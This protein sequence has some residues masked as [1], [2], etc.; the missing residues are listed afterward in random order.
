MIIDTNNHQYRIWWQHIQGPKGNITICMLSTDG[1][2][3]G[4]NFLS[5]NSDVTYNKK[6]GRKVSF[7]R[8]VSIFNK[9]YKESLASNQTSS[10][11][12]KLILKQA[13]KATRVLFWK[14][15]WE[16]FPEHKRPIEWRIKELLALAQKDY[17]KSLEMEN[18]K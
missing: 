2:V 11:L 3:D 4:E 5:A 17:T 15:Y 13:S 7:T 1:K 8:L 6:L 18:T 16:R 12:P 14:A 10:Q 9:R